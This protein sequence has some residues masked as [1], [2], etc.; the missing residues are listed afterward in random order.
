[1][2]AHQNRLEWRLHFASEKFVPFNMPEELVGL[3]MRKKA[4]LE[5]VPLHQ[6]CNNPA[7][8]AMF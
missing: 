4:T 2:M 8:G 5:G 1:M 3:E 6:H 7:T